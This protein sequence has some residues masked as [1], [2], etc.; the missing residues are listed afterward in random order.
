MEVSKAEKVLS[1]LQRHTFVLDTAELQ[2]HENAAQP[3]DEGV[4]VDKH[5]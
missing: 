3:K 2:Q 5:G 1:I 4:A